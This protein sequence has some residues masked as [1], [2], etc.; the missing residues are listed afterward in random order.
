[1]QRYSFVRVCLGATVYEQNV[2]T[3]W[4]EDQEE[5]HQTPKLYKTSSKILVVKSVRS[6][7]IFS[8]SK[9]LQM[10]LSFTETNILLTSRDYKYS[11][12]FTDRRIYS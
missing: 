10:Q 1:M 2:L 12:R 3:E 5:Q 4:Q 11:Y 6:L 8:T 9:R 7:A